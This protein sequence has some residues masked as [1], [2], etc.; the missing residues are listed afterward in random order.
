M[1]N[2]PSVQAVIE[3]LRDAGCGS[4]CVEQFLALGKEGKTADQLRLLSA[5]RQR[6]LDQIHR[7][8]KRVECLD[9]LVYR[10]EKEARE[11]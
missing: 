10:I 8:E 3:N 1:A 9:Y 11:S 7:G 6:L 4:R 2:D 5:H